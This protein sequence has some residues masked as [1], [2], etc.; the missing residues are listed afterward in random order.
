METTNSFG[1]WIRRQ[2]KALDL[3][4]QALADKVGCSIAAI[5][6]GEPGRGVRLLAAFETG[7]G[8]HGMKLPDRDP[9]IMVLRQALVRARVQLGPATYEAAW[10]EGQRMTMEQAL[11]LATESILSN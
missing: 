10:A 7:L 3:T 5:F 2:R 9:S 4:Q 11:A 6:G 8:Q 1:Y